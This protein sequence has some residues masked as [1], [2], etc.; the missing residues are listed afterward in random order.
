MTKKEKRRLY[1]LIPIYVFLVVLCIFSFIRFYKSTHV[2]E[3]SGGDV[4]YPEMK[5]FVTY[6]SEK[7]L[8]TFDKGV[9]VVNYVYRIDTTETS[10]FNISLHSDN[11][12]DV[13]C[14][15]NS[16]TY[17]IYDFSES[18]NGEV[19]YEIHN[20]RE[21]PDDSVFFDRK[22]RE[23]RYA[24]SFMAPLIN[25]VYNESVYEGNYQ[26]TYSW[27]AIF[28]DKALEIFVERAIDGDNWYDL[29]AYLDK[30]GKL[31]RYH[32][33][34]W[35]RLYNFDGWQPYYEPRIRMNLD[36]VIAGIHASQTH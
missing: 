1:W 24:G 14:R 29:Y 27:Y 18:Y 25:R 20:D 31:I 19:F 15:M 35:G 3:I 4:R 16:E 10:F 26:L 11:G 17:C 34:L 22:L 2:H 5:F 9:E 13:A 30:N 12:V 7:G 32:D 33:N 23:H 28:H 6:R 21:I 36:K 8:S